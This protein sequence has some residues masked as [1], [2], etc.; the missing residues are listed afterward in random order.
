[1]SDD[2]QDKVPLF[3][4][5]RLVRELREELAAAKG[6]EETASAQAALASTRADTAEG[7]L[8]ALGG[9]EYSEVQREIERGREQVRR[10]AAEA[11]DAMEKLAATRRAIVETEDVAA[12]QE[13]GVYEYRHPLSDAVEYQAQLKTL[14]ASIKEMARAN[15]G[16]V[17]GATDWVVNGSAPEGRKMVRE[18]CKLMLRAYN[19]EAD[20]LVRGLKPY[21]LDQ[22]LARLDRA[23]E[24]IQKLGRTMTV[25]V[26][27]RYHRLRRRELEMTADYLARKEEEKELERAERARM[28]EEA[29]VQAE[30]ERER[31]R[32]EKE[33]AHYANAL[34]ALESS[35]DDEAAGRLRDQLEDVDRA[36]A[37]VDYRVANIRAGYVYVISNVGSFGDEVVKI[38]LTRRLD[39]QERVREL[40]DASVPFR[41]DVHALYFSKDAVTLEQQ[42]HERFADRRINRVNARRE[43]FRVTPGEVKDAMQELAG[44]L[45]EFADVPEALEYRQSLTEQ[46]QRDIPTGA[47]AHGAMTTF[48]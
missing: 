5:R 27:P 14:R 31:K 21:K 29:K 28:R 3:G 8:E 22:A 32:L 35:G 36:I 1:M 45:L 39:P 30:M 46:G 25:E 23:V 13:V 2:N 44:D 17:T 48:P 26:S 6:R 43:F 7:A 16:A 18:T 40:G 12:L 9:L 24:V 10:L 20:N 42:L 41:Y 34:T 47:A 38:G 11:E 37:D 19:A 4:A 15:G 33:R